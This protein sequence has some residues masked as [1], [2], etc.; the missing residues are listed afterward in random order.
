M[1]VIRTFIAIRLP[2]E[3]EEGLGKLA[4][5]MRTLWP[6]RGV[7]WVKPGNIHLTLRFLGDT[8]EGQVGDIGEGLKEV[9]SRHEALALAL[10]QSGCFPNEKRPGVIWTGIEDGAGRLQKL[11]Q[12]V[13]ALVCDL[14]W[15]RE[16]RE[17]R[18]HLTLGRVRQGVRPP[19]GAWLQDPVPLEFRVGEVELI[20]SELKPGGVEYLTLCRAGLKIPGV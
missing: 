8:E 10:G 9:A 13:E 15:E 1:G 17:Y 18:P 14:G 7:R 2:G 12:D 6:E 4:K 5:K 16:G 3:I 20:Q 11:Q 19:N